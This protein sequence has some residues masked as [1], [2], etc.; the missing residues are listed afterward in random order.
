MWLMVGIRSQSIG[1]GVA[2]AN[3][4]NRVI[5]PEIALKAA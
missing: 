4:L 5:I 2:T 3:F 1:P